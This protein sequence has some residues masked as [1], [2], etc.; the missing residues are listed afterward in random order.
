MVNATIEMTDLILIRINPLKIN[1]TYL[2]SF[3][4]NLRIFQLSSLMLNLSTISE[5]SL[6]RLMRL[7]GI[8]RTI[9]LCIYIASGNNLPTFNV[10]IVFLYSVNSIKSSINSIRVS[11]FRGVTLIINDIKFGYVLVNLTVKSSVR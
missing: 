6:I 1:Y 2:K 7:E 4:Y 10:L 9:L 5:I 11:T 8:L 3:L